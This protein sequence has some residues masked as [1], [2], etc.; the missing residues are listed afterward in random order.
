MGGSWPERAAN[1]TRLYAKSLFKDYSKFR[2]Q[3]FGII[4]WVT[5]TESADPKKKNAVHIKINC[6][7]TFSNNT[8]LCAINDGEQDKKIYWWSFHVFLYMLYR[9]IQYIEIPNVVIL[10]FRVLQTQDLW[11]MWDI[12][13]FFVC[14]FR[15]KLHVG[16]KKIFWP[17]NI[18]N[19]PFFFW[20]EFKVQLSVNILGKAFRSRNPGEFF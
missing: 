5:K 1:W 18:W 19:L 8:Q 2:F 20:I 15:W 4:V 7:K 9:Y 3:E 11:K 13:F 12:T 10:H 17:D 6:C 16:L 14:F